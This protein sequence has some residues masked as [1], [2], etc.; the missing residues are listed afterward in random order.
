M[1]P[2]QSL[3]LYIALWMSAVVTN[4]SDDPPKLRGLGTVPADFF[5][6]PPFDVLLRGDRYFIGR[7]DAD[8][9]F[10][11]N[12]RG[13]PQASMT[14]HGAIPHV[15]ANNATDNR[16]KFEHRSGRLIRGTIVG[17]PRGVFVPEI[18]S[19]VLDFKKDYDPK[20][21]NRKIYNM[22]I[23]VQ[24]SPVV[25]Q[26]EAAGSPP[27]W[28]LIPYR[29]YYRKTSEKMDP[30][31][32]RVI[33][34]VMELGHLTDEGEFIPDYGLP[35]FPYVKVQD[36]HKLADASNRSI[37]Y[38]LPKDDKDKEEVYEFRSGRLIKGTLHKT[39][40]FVPELGSKI[41]D[42][43]DYNPLGKRRIYNVPGVLR[44]TDK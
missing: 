43:K 22:Q 34:D 30:W 24:P 42:F 2:M 7:F 18:G 11:P 32:A 5:R 39:G 25:P 29:E 21:A 19:T 3:T 9:N 27:G 15:H 33:G 8:G 41:L 44:Q 6:Q 37:Y 4:P 1:L 28:R 10:V 13:N 16:A 23:F 20:T 36:P 31:F 17:S 38:T 12:A 26:P 35:V 40:N 14:I